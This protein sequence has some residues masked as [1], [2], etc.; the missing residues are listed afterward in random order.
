MDGLENYPI[1]EDFHDLVIDVSTSFQLKG[2]ITRV[3]ICLV[4]YILTIFDR[5]MNK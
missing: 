1:I 5:P 2:L 3:I 4:K